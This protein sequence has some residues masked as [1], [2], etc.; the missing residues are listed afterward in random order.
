M[1]SAF[2]KKVQTKG[3]MRVR[4]SN[5]VTTARTNAPEDNKNRNQ[6]NALDFADIGIK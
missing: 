4:Y 2:T 1:S 3:R 5:W 6:Y